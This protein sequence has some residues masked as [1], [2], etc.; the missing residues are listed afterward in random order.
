[1]AVLS[2]PVGI[3][4]E[5]SIADGRVAAAVVVL[6]Q[7]AITDGGVPLTDGKRKRAGG[8]VEIALGV[9]RK[10][11]RA[12][13]PCLW[14]PFLGNCIVLNRGGSSRWRCLLTP[15]GVEL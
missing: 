15:V 11:E 1:M 10:G 7:C 5:R 9:V 6:I 13:G 14:Y 12:S 3:V 2:S 4:Y 8:C